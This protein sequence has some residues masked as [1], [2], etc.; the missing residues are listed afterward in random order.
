MQSQLYQCPSRTRDYSFDNLKSILVLDVEK[1]FPNNTNCKVIVKL[2]RARNNDM[3][4]NVTDWDLDQLQAASES[5]MIEK[6]QEKSD[7]EADLP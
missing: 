1:I 6:Q 3:S 5:N 4:I 7:N 2:N